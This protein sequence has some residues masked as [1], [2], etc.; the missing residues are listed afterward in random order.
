M[1][2][3]Q[4]IGAKTRQR[5]LHI[6]LFVRLLS[7]VRHL[8]RWELQ[9]TLYFLLW[10]LGVGIFLSRQSRKL[11]NCCNKQSQI[12]LH[13]DLKLKTMISLQNSCV[14]LL[15]FSSPYATAEDAQVDYSGYHN[16]EIL[17][18]LFQA[19]GGFD[20]TDSTNWFQQRTD[21]CEW[22]GVTCYTDTE[23]DGRRNGHIRQINLR[24][25]NLK[26]TVPAVVFE[27]PFLE[28]LNVEDNA[29]LNIDFSGL[30][31]A[32]FLNDLSISKTDVDDISNIGAGSNLKILHM[33]NL[34]LKG[35][36][37]DSLFDLTA[38]VALYANFNSFSGTIPASI[39]R[40]SSLD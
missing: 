1:D 9:T 21:L 27:I 2:G 12:N 6:V 10:I 19:T 36:L 18:G 8:S 17:L 25:N 34:G 32:Q 20:W 33:T 13:K 39:G 28:S 5:I 14:L 7:F 29:D 38:L 23:S 22:K 3:F 35:S 24:S 16:R 15:A 11:K 4:E 40:L 31:K 37:P 26:G 30:N